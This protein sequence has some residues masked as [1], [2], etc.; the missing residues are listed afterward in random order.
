M[1]PNQTAPVSYAPA[2]PAPG[3]FGTRIPS[4]VAFVVGVLLFFL[5]FT[6]IRC[7]GSKLA[8]K[9]GYDFAMQNEWKSAM[10]GLGGDELKSKTS[11]TG[12]EQEGNTRLYILIAAGLGVLGLLLSMGNAKLGGGGAL[13][14]GILAA[15][16]LVAFMI[17]LKKNFSNSI[18]QQAL[19]KAN[20]GAE[21]LGLDNMNA[22]T[23]AFTP[24]FY[25][26]VV[27]FAA[28]AIFGV[29]RMRAART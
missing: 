28:A 19:E 29:M 4:S 8:T 7:G 6:E 22:I 9:S 1:E 15:G 5:P 11:N 20:E 12:K 2:S 14:T 26:A 21:S 23:L 24:W 17:E 16:C 25:I 18:R 10:G 13:L 27:A 3:I